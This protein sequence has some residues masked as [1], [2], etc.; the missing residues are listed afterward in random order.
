LMAEGVDIIFTIEGNTGDVV[1]RRTVS[2]TPTYILPTL[3]L[4]MRGE[5]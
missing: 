4:V 2:A 5:Q 3:P 1:R